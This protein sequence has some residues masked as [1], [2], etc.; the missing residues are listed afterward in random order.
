MTETEQLV[1]NLGKDVAVMVE[2]Q[3][4]FQKYQVQTT[5]N[6]DKLTSSVNKLAQEAIR[7]ESIFGN[8]SNMD[9]K[10]DSLYSEV[11]SRIGRLEDKYSMWSKTLIG[12]IA[13]AVIGTIFKF[14]GVQ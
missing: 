9:K 8:L 1:Y 13:V 6:I 3:K 10:I 12:T 5:A 7:L 4:A 14:V 11:S 2:T